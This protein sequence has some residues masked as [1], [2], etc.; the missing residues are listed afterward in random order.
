MLVLVVVLASRRRAASSRCSRT[1]SYC[2]TASH[3]DGRA[4]LDTLRALGVDRLRVTVLWAAIAPA[5]DLDDR[6]GRL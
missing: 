1:T 4:T 5:A 6:A 3:A 2:C